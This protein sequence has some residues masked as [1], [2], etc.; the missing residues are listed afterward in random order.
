MHI[1]KQGQFFNRHQQTSPQVSLA[2]IWAILLPTENKE[3]DITS[4]LCSYSKI[5]FSYFLKMTAVPSGIL[6]ADKPFLTLCESPLE[7]YT[8]YACLY[9][10]VA[11]QMQSYRN[12]QWDEILQSDNVLPC[13]I[14]SVMDAEVIRS[15]MCKQQ[16]TWSLLPQ[17]S[18]HRKNWV[19]AML[20]GELNLFWSWHCIQP[21]HLTR[22]TTFELT[23]TLE[24]WHK[25]SVPTRGLW[26]SEHRPPV[27]PP[28]VPILT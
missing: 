2:D 15:A 3:A 19:V 6:D 1:N 12:R 25:Q 17:L 7:A 11:P 21:P 26:G 4:C 10:Y 14:V 27:T 9:V 13:F 20:S 8:V 28:S 16:R 23:S 18:W 22:A 5:R 24:K